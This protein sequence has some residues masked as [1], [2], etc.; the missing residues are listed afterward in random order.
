MSYQIIGNDGRTYGPASAEQVRLWI[1]Q[2]RA[3]SRI[4]VLV[5]GSNTWSV[6]GLLPEFAP[7]F[8]APPPLTAAANPPP[9]PRQF[10]PPGS[11][12]TNSLA[13]AGLVFGI[14]SLLCCCCCGGFPFNILG[15]VFSLIALVQIN[16]HPEL[17]SGRAQA[18]AGIALSAVSFLIFLAEV[19]SNHAQVI[20]HDGSF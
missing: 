15:L 1:S 6:L 11:V 20:M 10:V 17:Y 4:P 14:L 9:P 18:I 8:A 5:E 12:T 19:A 7:L 2:G 3:E 16:D 13:T